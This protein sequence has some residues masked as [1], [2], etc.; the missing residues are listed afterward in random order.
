MLQFKGGIRSLTPAEIY[1]KQSTTAI[2]MD[3]PST[4]GFD[5]SFDFGTGAGFINASAALAALVP[6]VPVAVPAPPTPVA[7]PVAP[8]PLLVPVV[9]TPVAVPIAPTPV[10]VPVLVPVTPT[11]VAVP[12]SKV[13]CIT[14]VRLLIIINCYDTA[15]AYQCATVACKETTRFRHKNSI[16]R[17]AFPWLRPISLFSSFSFLAA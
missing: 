17:R 9:P 14:A 2:D 12:G 16:D 3:D 1:S 6:P 8:T 10:A 4:A 7:V 15:A 13:A 11:A 5:V